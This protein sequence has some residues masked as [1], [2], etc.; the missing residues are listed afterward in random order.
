MK[1]FIVMTAV[2]P[3][4]LI[5]MLQFTVEQVNHHHISHL[6]QIVNE[7]AQVAKQDGFFT[8]ENI[9][10]MRTEIAS[11]FSISPA[12]IVIEADTTPKYRVNRF[13]ER[14]LIHYK[15]QV[16][17]DRLVAGSSFFGISDSENR[18]MYTIES[19]TASELLMT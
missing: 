3:F 8:E 12:E 6:Q 5:F 19:Y 2:L 16:P 9:N 10:R 14:E 13:D 1:Q 15:V 17:I 4:L 11:V 18:G 7:S